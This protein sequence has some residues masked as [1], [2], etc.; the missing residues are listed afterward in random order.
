MDSLLMMKI[1]DKFDEDK[2]FQSIT[3]IM[4]LIINKLCN[5]SQSRGTNGTVKE[6]LYTG[7][8]RVKLDSG[9]KWLYNPRC[10][11]MLDRKTDSNKDRD[12]REVNGMKQGTRVRIKDLG[13]Q[14]MKVLQN[15]YGGYNTQMGLVS[16]ILLI[17]Y[18][19][20]LQS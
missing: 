4:F 5:N 3:T 9:Q 8:V 2:F 16:I 1:S 19:I 14:E 11:S 20:K 13:I 18:I 7:S 17:I 6:V 15:T 10:L 12:Q